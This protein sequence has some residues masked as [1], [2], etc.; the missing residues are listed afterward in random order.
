MIVSDHHSWEHVVEEAFE[1][2]VRAYLVLLIE[3]VEELVE[4]GLDDINLIDGVEGSHLSVPHIQ[5]V[6]VV[7]VCYFR[8]DTS[9]HSRVWKTSQACSAAI[10]SQ[11]RLVLT[12]SRLK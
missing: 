3:N 9:F 6:S 2:L 12:Q 5:G 8:P 11:V 7:W 4:V 10:F 1:L